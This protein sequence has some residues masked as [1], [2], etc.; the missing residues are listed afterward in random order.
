M[1]VYVA[2]TQ[3]SNIQVEEGARPYADEDNGGYATFYQS[4]RTW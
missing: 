4:G 2:E 3:L 1:P